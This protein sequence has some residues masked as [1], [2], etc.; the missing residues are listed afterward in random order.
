MANRIHT[1]KLVQ[2]TAVLL[3]A[4]AFCGAQVM[5]TPGTLPNGGQ[6][7]VPPQLFKHQHQ[8]P[9]QAMPPQ[10]VPPQVAQPQPVQP[11]ADQ[12]A[13]QQASQPAPVLSRGLPPSLL[14]K[15]AQPAKVSLGSG[16]LSVQ[17][18]NSSLTQILHDLSSSTGMTIDGLGK[19]QRVFGSYG[20]ANPRDVLS[21]LLQD[22]GYNVMMVGATAQGAPRQLLLTP[23]SGDA[24][25][26]AAQPRPAQ[27]QDDADDDP[28]AAQE[29]PN[30]PPPGAVP[31]PNPPGQNQPST[32]GAVRTPQQ[33][34]QDLQQIR[35]QQQQQQP[36]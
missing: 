4:A 21:A 25:G 3:A 6:V 10:N 7:P 34:L 16:D 17:A 20:P 26:S 28:P 8:D 5:Q 1:G 30:T 19:D 29:D 23:R 12:A 13:A 15:P 36:Q 31:S 32:P 11:P 33:M 27:N 14:D 35:S 22:S 9:Q 24:L 2:T 18:E